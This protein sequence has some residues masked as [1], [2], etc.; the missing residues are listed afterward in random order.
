LSTTNRTQLLNWMAA[1]QTGDTMIRA[2]LPS[3]WKEANKTGAGEFQARNI[4]SVITPPS[5]QRIWLAAFLL[6]ARSTLDQRNRHFV[7]L[8]RAIVESLG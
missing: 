5:G 1:S 2:G 8:G 4:V 7:P 6:A 3:G